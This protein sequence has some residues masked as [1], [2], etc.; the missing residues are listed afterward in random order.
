MTDILRR[1]AV[2]I[3]KTLVK[4]AGFTAVGSVSRGKPFRALVGTILSHRTRDEKTEIASKTLLSRYPN[5][6]SL[7]KAPVSEI[8]RLIR[9]VGFYRVKAKWLKNIAEILI[10]DFSSKVPDSYEKLLTLP[11]VGRKTAGCVLVYGF[12]KP[13]IP[14]DTHVHRIANRLGL[15][16]TKTPEQTEKAL[17]KLLPKR[18]WLALNQSF[19][20]YGKKICKPVRPLC[21]LCRIAPLCNYTAGKSLRSS[22]ANWA[23]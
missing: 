4:D 14:V 18:Y 17:A 9:G 23:L 6:R 19:V 3:V 2:L 20:E 5:P 15:V 12:G 1:R 21:P 11:G 16:S 8:A 10:R 7:A 22:A 13:A